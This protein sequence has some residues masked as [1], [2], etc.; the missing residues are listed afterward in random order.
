MNQKFIISAVFLIF[1]LTSLTKCTEQKN[2][3]KENLT[4]PKKEAQIAEN[5]IK[6]QHNQENNEANLRPERKLSLTTIDESGGLEPDRELKH[7]KKK[8][9]KPIPV[10]KSKFKLKKPPKLLKFGNITPKYNPMRKK[11]FKDIIDEL[12]NPVP[13]EKLI[14]KNGKLYRKPQKRLP[15]HKE[16][17]KLWQ[18]HTKMYPDVDK[19][20]KMDKDLEAL[21]DPTYAIPRPKVYKM[22][23]L[24]N[25][26]PVFL[27]EYHGDMEHDYFKLHFPRLKPGQE[28]LTQ[29]K[30]NLLK[31]FRIDPS[32]ETIDVS[33]MIQDGK[34]CKNYV[35]AKY[36]NNRFYRKKNYI[37]EVFFQNEKPPGNALR[38][39]AKL[40]NHVPTD[41]KYYGK[42]FLFTWKYQC[43]VIRKKMMNPRFFT[44]VP[45]IDEDGNFIDELYDVNAKLKD[46]RVFKDLLF[47]Y[48][49]VLK[50]KARPIYPEPIYSKTEPIP[51]AE[52]LI[53]RRF[54]T[55]LK[56]K[57]DIV[58]HFIGME[59]MK[60]DMRD[61]L[62]NL[63]KDIDEYKLYY[64]T[65]VALG[66]KNYQ[67]ELKS[68]L[69]HFQKQLYSKMQKSKI[70]YE[71]FQQKVY[72]INKYGINRSMGKMRGKLDTLNDMQIYYAKRRRFVLEEHIR[73]VIAFL[74][75]VQYFREK[76]LERRIFEGRTSK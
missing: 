19:Y 18:A 69:W 25:D 67:D 35:V 34:K 17:I 66:E 2:I 43:S 36:F 73:R 72:Y 32:Q 1:C 42:N 49:G 55:V 63:K 56:K 27:L 29:V 13:P 22:K 23:M 26:N 64:K 7:Y 31:W 30:K 46:G 3:T 53:K 5:S 28:K 11:F 75:Y 6:N 62:K 10:G 74:H 70:N 8:K 51:D 33:Y 76:T 68:Q 52:T 61:S 71:I 41:N 38:A 50:K 57:Y 60:K 15:P 14:K 12:P 39:K 44:C 4:T 47:S 58:K 37:I 40:V 9:K 24:E 48:L 59:F 45:A 16:Y 54:E 65:N 20:Q 21:I